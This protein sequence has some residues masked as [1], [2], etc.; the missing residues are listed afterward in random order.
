MPPEPDP[1]LA[2]VRPR[3]RPGPLWL[4]YTCTC[5]IVAILIGGFVASALN[6]RETTLRNTEHN[7]HNVSIT[8]AE[9][10]NRSLQGLDLVL[11][12]LEELIAAEGVVD[13]AT[14]QQ[15]MSSE[16]VHRTLQEKLV[17]LPYINA[18]VMLDAQ[19]N[20]INF[21]RFWPVPSLNVA[22]RDSFKPMAENP[23]LDRY[24]SMPMPNRLLGT[25]SSYFV[26]HV[27]GP[28]GHFAGVLQGSIELKYFEDFYRTVSLGEGSSISLVRQD[29]VQMVR[30]P[31][32]NAVGKRFP[33]GM[34]R[35]LQGGAD[36]VVRDISPVDGQMRIMAAHTL[37]D[38]PLFVLATETQDAALR[39][40][41]HLV[42]V[43]GLVTAGCAGA[44]IIAALA[45]GRWWRQQHALGQARAEHAEAEHARARAEA[46]LLRERGRD[47]EGASRAKSGFL[48]MMSHEIRTPMNAVLGLAGSLLDASLTP[49]QHEVVRTI[50]DSGDSLL[51]ILNDILD[52]S[53]LDA[54]RMTFEAAPFSPATLTHNAISILGPRARAKGLAIVAQA[55]P[56]LPAGLL[57]DAGRIR[58]VLLNLVS[59]AVKFTDAGAVT[60]GA[61]RVDGDGDAIT[62]E[63]SIQDTGIGIAPDRI[64]SLFGE[65]VQ[66]DSSINRR[67]GGSGLGLAISKQ[68][69]EQMGGTIG[70]ESTEG[71]GTIF[72]VRLTLPIAEAPADAQP[73]PADATRAMEALLTTLGRPLRILFAEDNPTNQFVARQL[74]KGLAVQ[75]DVVGDG[76]E[77]VD[78]ASRFAYDMIFMDMRMPEMDGLAATRLIRQRGG[79]LARVPIVALTANAFPEDVKACFDAGMNQFVTKPVSKDVLFAA[80]LRGL[81]GS[82]SPD[83][84]STDAGAAEASLAFDAAALHALGEDIGHDSVAEMLEVFQQETLA[85]LQRMAVPGVPSVTLMREAHTLKGAAGTVCAPLL[86]RRAEAIEARLRAGAP[87]EPGDLGG[88]MAALQAFTTAVE[89]TG[90]MS[91]VVV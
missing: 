36:G 88:L 74:L 37:T 71:A 85:R 4:L 41:R 73:G 80:V 10:A 43:L 5:L 27:L 68:L 44:I 16:R 66:A 12:S 31:P 58:Q 9:Q 50:R 65:F 48:A 38:F 15:K 29:G 17:G 6:L 24:I 77:A 59:N 32:A 14:Y 89:T 70:V 45:I 46:D 69:T 57:G 64:G 1:A 49:A 34:A 81:S 67:F 75:V 26:R 72:R 8:L 84:L 35:V 19:G 18:I 90:V 87:I 13:S 63:W 52:Y 51:R 2:A 30:Y 21:S 91:K 76:L 33:N 60:I 56:A 42:W 62:I 11:T 82:V 23:K 53:K 47:A 20:L 40:W 86:R 28:D 55:D 7:L 3:F 78:A 39:E 79:P 22:D 61:H 25:W 83:A 54:G